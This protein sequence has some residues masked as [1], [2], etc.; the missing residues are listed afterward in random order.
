MEIEGIKIVHA[1]PGRVRVK[2]AKLKGNVT[3]A[4]RAQEK[5]SGIPGI[6]RVEAN[7]ATGSIL[8]LHE[9]AELFSPEALEELSETLGELFPEIGAVGLMAGLASLSSSSGP[10]EGSPG[11]G[12]SAVS[13]ITGS[14][15][16]KL[17][18]PLTLLFFGVRALVV[19]EKVT[20]PAWYDL[21]WFAFGSFM[22]LSRNPGQVVD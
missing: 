12:G 21:L 10:G 8:I 9:L 20:F 14:V 17:L 6:R 22:M 13:R 15:D 11:P 18:L 1:M 5:L 7:P 3:L 19:S 16:L 2:V 4:Q